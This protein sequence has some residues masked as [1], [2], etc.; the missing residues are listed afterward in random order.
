MRN[1][2]FLIGGAQYPPDFP[3]TGN[4]FYVNHLPPAEHP[5]FFCSSPLTLNVTRAPM[6]AM[7]HCPSGRLFESA[8]CGVPVV[9]DCWDGI[10][11]FFRPG[12]EILVARCADD[13]IA[14]VSRSPEELARIGHAARERTLQEHTAVS[15]ADELV[16]IIE[17][18]R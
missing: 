11:A 17:G 6:A 13:V 12:E 2:R 18:A 15:R 16:R 4:I 14:A 5:A 10:E 7:G 9:T 1:R 8:A 3:W